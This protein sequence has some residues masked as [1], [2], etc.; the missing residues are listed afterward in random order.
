M[1]PVRKA[2]EPHPDTYVVCLECGKQFLYDM[3][4]MRMGKPVPVSP[5]DGVL[6]EEPPASKTKKLGYAALALPLAWGVSSVFKRFKKS[7]DDRKL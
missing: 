7:G 1:T 5:T 6:Y 3:Q 2:G 4:E